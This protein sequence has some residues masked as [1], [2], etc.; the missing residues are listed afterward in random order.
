MAKRYYKSPRRSVPWWGNKQFRTKRA[1]YKAGFAR[2]RTYG[3]KYGDR[4]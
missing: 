1:A 3:S 2:G 4:Q